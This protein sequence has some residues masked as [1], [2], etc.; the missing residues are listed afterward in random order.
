MGLCLR[1]RLNRYKGNNFIFV[2]FIK[3]SYVSDRLVEIA[4][5]TFNKLFRSHPRERLIIMNKIMLIFLFLIISNLLFSEDLESIKRK[6]NNIPIV[7][8]VLSEWEIVSKWIK[9]A[10]NNKQIEYFKRLACEGDYS[11]DSIILLEYISMSTISPDYI[12]ILFIKSLKSNSIVA[13]GEYDAYTGNVR[14][15]TNF[16]ENDIIW[17][18]SKDEAI[19]CL[20]DNVDLSNNFIVEIKAFYMPLKP[21]DDCYKDWFWSILVNN[22]SDNRNL[23]DVFLINPLCFGSKSK[24][25]NLLNNTVPI[26]YL[27]K[28]RRYRIYKIDSKEDVDR[29][30][31]FFK[32][33]NELKSRNNCNF[34][35]D[36]SLFKF[37]PI[38]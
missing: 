26:N 4:R 34:L 32:I 28:N 14:K 19:Q 11:F 18:L 9:I 13:S 2:Y 8:G 21:S 23:K 12:Y 33:K 36:S 30:N 20:K 5:K 27:N 7:S 17:Y 29:Y 22:K 3:Y 24:N 1:R 25:I 15:E 35:S 10:R 31:N 16:L 6:V 37:S 38:K